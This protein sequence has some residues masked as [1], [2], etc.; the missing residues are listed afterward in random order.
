MNRTY[1][2]FNPKDREIFRTMKKMMKMLFLKMS[3][4]LIQS[5][6]IYCTTFSPMT[7][8]TIQIYIFAAFIRK[9]LSI[10]LSKRKQ[11]IIKLFTFLLNHSIY[12][13]SP[14]SQSIEKYQS[15]C[16]T[17]SSTNGRISF[18][19]TLQSVGSTI[20]TSNSLSTVASNTPLSNFSIYVNVILFI[21]VQ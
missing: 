13:I 10:P 4:H 18:K 16:P 14:L 2:T 12:V 20:K 1:L 6:R 21:S 11:E 19:S 5:T 15:S 3:L 9:K 7:C 17:L 8:P